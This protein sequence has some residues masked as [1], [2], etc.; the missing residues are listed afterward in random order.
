MNCRNSIQD[1]EAKSSSRLRDEGVSFGARELTLQRRERLD[2]LGCLERTVS[3]VLPENVVRP[4]V[5]RRD[6]R[7]RDAARPGSAD[8]RLG[9]RSG[10]VTVAAGRPEPTVRAPGAV[11][12]G[13]SAR[14]TLA[15]QSQV[16]LIHDDQMVETFAPERSDHTLRDGV[17]LRC[18][19][20]SEEGSPGLGR[21]TPQRPPPIAPHRLRAH[22]VAERE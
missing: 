17:R 16:T 3:P 5:T 14:R 4:N 10:A 13:C 6:A 12:R 21:R 9:P 18:P 22:L 11:A 2:E 1:W 8:P 20:R 15:A 7:T 19:H